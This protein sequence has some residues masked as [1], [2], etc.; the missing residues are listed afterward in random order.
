MGCRPT[1]ALDTVPIRTAS[2]NSV[3]IRG[4]PE[5]AIN[6]DTLS[7]DGTLTSINLRSQVDWP[8]VGE[9]KLATFI[10]AGNLFVNNVFHNNPF[11]RVGAGLGLHYMTPVG[12]INLD[13]GR[14]LNP[15][16]GEAPNQIHFS[17]GLI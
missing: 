12:P 1:V 5:D 3:P 7:I 8:L 6:V 2:T 10:D 17:V 13:W 14:K 15:I 16:G 4:F 9:L 11:F